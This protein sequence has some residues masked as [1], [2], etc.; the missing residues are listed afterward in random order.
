MKESNFYSPEQKLFVNKRI[1]LFSRTLLP[2]IIALAIASLFSPA[3]RNLIDNIYV[4]VGFG[5]IVFSF[6]IFSAWQSGAG[7]KKIEFI[8]EDSK[9]FLFYTIK[10]LILVYLISIAYKFFPEFFDLLFLLT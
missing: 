5:I 4:V 6:F 10:L 8:K 9:K 1:K 7:N 2:I 3:I